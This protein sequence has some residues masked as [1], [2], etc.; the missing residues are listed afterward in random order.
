MACAPAPPPSSTLRPTVARRPSIHDVAATAG[1]SI[2]TVS[3][4]LSGK[5]RLPQETRDHVRRVAEQIGYEPSMHARGLA[6]GR[7]MLLGIQASG[8]DSRALVPQLAYFV[9]LLNAASATAMGHGYAL[10]LLPPDAPEDKV[11]RLSLDGAAIVDP[12]GDE[13]LLAALR[14]EGKPV[15]TAGRIP[16]EPVSRSAIDTDHVAAAIMVLDHLAQVG[17]ERPALLTTGKGPSYVADA[18]RGYR[19][20]CA[21]HKVRP[22]VVTVRGAPTE[23]AGERAMARVLA[24]D[25]AAIDGVYATLDALAIGALRATRAL[26]VGVPQE[27][28]IAAITDSAPLRAA[29]PPVTALDLHPEQIGARAIELL[30]GLVEGR[31]VKDGTEPVPV[32]LIPRA[33]TALRARADEPRA[34][35]EA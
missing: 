2:T 10:V 18:A 29:S 26:G 31:D 34:V 19:A 5:G 20:W 28:A 35:V 11:H 27:L 9:D 16:G 33:S 1:V 30:V 12:V 4:A 24:A 22:R 8:F 6:T 32:D 13:P 21:A 3:H 15:V 23:E 25:R 14:A 17:C 7:T